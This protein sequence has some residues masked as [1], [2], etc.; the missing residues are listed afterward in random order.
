MPDDCGNHGVLDD[1]G[2]AGRLGVE[3]KLGGVLPS[4]H[5][6]RTLP[7]S[8]SVQPVRANSLLRIDSVWLGE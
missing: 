7:S 2:G 1:G 4:G 6:C 3:V 8:F 5:T